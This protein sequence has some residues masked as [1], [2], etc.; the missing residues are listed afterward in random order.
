MGG[1]DSEEVTVGFV[2]KGNSTPK[3]KHVR[4]PFR[5]G[6]IVFPNRTESWG[7]RLIK[8]KV[9]ETKMG[10]LQ[11]VEPNNPD[12]TGEVEFLPYGDK[13]GYSIEARYKKGCST[14]DYQYQLRVGYPSYFNDLEHNYIE[15]PSGV[16]EFEYDIDPVLIS[17]LKIHHENQNSESKNPNSEGNMFREVKVFDTKERDVKE[18][19]NEFEAVSIVKQAS[20]F[21][22]LDV[23]KTILSAVKEI[24]Y[25]PEKEGSLYDNIVI[26]AR[27]RSV[28]F[29]S[30][31]NGYK[32]NVSQIIELGKSYEVFDLT[33]DNMV[34]IL[35]PQKEVLIEEVKVK[36][37]DIP[38]WLF[39]NCLDPV[40][41]KAIE[42]LST[43]SK[44]FK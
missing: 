41:Y 43:Y 9:P 10:T 28:D 13:N 18:I 16:N 22:K 36:G 21:E 29:L 7:R 23:L 5:K 12:Y 34:V 38:Q 30:A 3:G 20:S 14:L 11:R 24:E 4:V 19:D 40:V 35:K 44:K 15:F 8:G 1:N 37:E 33:T 25:N 26:F 39:D 31:I 42:K 2:E 17:F 27:Q 32:R 6:N